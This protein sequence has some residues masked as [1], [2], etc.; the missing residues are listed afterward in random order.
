MDAK[1][2]SRLL[3][4]IDSDARSID[5]ICKFYYK[6]IVL[7]VGAKFG[8]Q[9]A[10]DVAQDFFINLLKKG[11]EQTKV[12]FPTTWVFTCCENIA[13]R[14][15]E[16]QHACTGHDADRVCADVLT[17]IEMYGDLFWEMQKLSEESRQILYLFY[18]EGYNQLEIA[19]ILGMDYAKVRQKHHRAVKKLKNLMGSVTK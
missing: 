5:A 10:E 9:L 6:R 13:K 14:K 4:T 3:K 8:K 16:T 7:H 11:G 12:E 2:F 19:G 18:W 1:E 17:E 15:L